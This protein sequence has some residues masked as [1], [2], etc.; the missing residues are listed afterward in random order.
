MKAINLSD[1]QPKDDIKEAIEK[2]TIWK[3]SKVSPIPGDK[4]VFNAGEIGRWTDEGE[5]LLSAWLLTT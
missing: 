4:Y 5:W 2:G 1:L 3:G